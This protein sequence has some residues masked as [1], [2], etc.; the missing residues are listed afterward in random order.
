MFT[1]PFILPATLLCAI[2]LA[3]LVAGPIPQLD[4]YHA[5]ADQRSLLGIANAADVL[6]NLGFLAVGIHGLAMVQRARALPHLDDVRFSYGLFF[7]ALIATAAGSSWYHLAPDDTR[8][9]FDR[10]PI[11]LACAGLLAAVA[12]RHLAAPRC[13]NGLLVAFAVGSVAWWG[14]TGDLR[15]YLLLQAAPLVAI[16]AVMYVVRARR[17]EVTAY[18]AAIACYAAAKGFELADHAVFAALP[19]SG[20][21]I[22]H[23]LATAGTLC[24][25]RYFGAEA[26]TVP[27]G[28]PRVR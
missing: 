12:R 1:R 24:I 22:K 11:A 25:A 5:F 28:L 9:L 8:L 26:A 17:P 13:I 20:H 10:L 3:M 6:S 27:A 14:L 19:L 2:A 7:A 4:D 16:P 23:I 18:A 15:P 21:T